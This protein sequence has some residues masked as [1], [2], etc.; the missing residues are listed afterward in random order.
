MKDID[1]DFEKLKQ[2]AYAMTPPSKLSRHER[3][4]ASTLAKTNRQ[5][6]FFIKHGKEEAEQMQNQARHLSK[7]LAAKA[8]RSRFVM[9]PEKN[10]YLG[11]WDVVTTLAL[12]YTA[13]VTPFETSFIPPTIGPTA[14]QDPWFIANRFLDCIFGIDLFVQFFVAFQT[15]NDFG[16]RQ[17]VLDQSLVTRHYVTGWF[18]VDLL[19]VVVPLTFDI[20]LA[21]MP[22]P[23]GT[24]TLDPSALAIERMGTFRVLRVLRLV[25]LVRLLRASR[26]FERWKSKITLN[27]AQQTVLTVVFALV[28]LSHWYA[29]IIALGASMHVDVDSTWVGSQLY[30]LCNPDV[31]TTRLVRPG[32]LAGCESLSTERFYL[33]ALSWSVMIITGTGG[34]DFYPSGES[35]AETVLV[36][37]LV[38]LGAFLWTLVLASFCDVATN[39]TPALT[40]FRQRLDGLNLY[41]EIN[42]IQP[43]LAR[44]LRSFMHQQKGVQLR[45][46]AKLALP[47]LSPALQIETTLYVHRHWLESI[48]FVKNLEAPVKVRLAMAMEPKVLAP[49]EVAPNRHLYVISRGSVIFGGRVL[50]R[51]MCW[52]DDVILE[53]PANFISHLARALSYV[54]VTSLSRETLL[55]IISAY[56]NSEYSL[57]RHTL[58]LAL[59]RSIITNAKDLLRHVQAGGEIKDFKAKKGSLTFLSKVGEAA[60]ENMTATQRQ[61]MNIALSLG[62][63][64]IDQKLG[65]E[66][67]TGGGGTDT[68]GPGVEASLNA[69]KQEMSL[70]RSEMAD[71][72]HRL[73]R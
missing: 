56:P 43:D 28:T 44:R 40:V 59:R 71:L 50:S 61:S 4:T 63:S 3:L 45:E 49:G 20:Y 26:L 24:S 10:R 53:N 14:W 25:K 62:K 32:P 29:C 7:V 19:T 66:G 42:D 5:E 16:G 55:G 2:S 22:S 23:Q 8:S 17:W 47:H 33:A 69:L 41:I 60:E 72:K 38:V 65:A 13:T 35:D 31:D 30:G 27:Y 46:D 67:P 70:M 57:K 37:I 64:V 21:N 51:N 39:S 18:S 54:D 58:W 6:K 36:C 34:T 52:G 48:W 11:R 12:L 68:I 73:S 15:G 1:D 9:H